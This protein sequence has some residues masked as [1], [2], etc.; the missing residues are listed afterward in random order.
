MQA[1]SARA[2]LIALSLAAAASPVR[3]DDFFRDLNVYVA[4]GAGGEMVWGGTPAPGKGA[5]AEL[6]ILAGRLRWFAFEGGGRIGKHEGTFLAEEKK[7]RVLSIGFNGLVYFASWDS[8]ELFAQI[9]WHPFLVGDSSGNDVV[10]G[11]GIDYWVATHVTVGVR[12]LY[13]HLSWEPVL[14][15]STT[16]AT[17]LS[18]GLMLAF[19]LEPPPHYVAF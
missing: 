18:L 13:H 5:N 4:A 3:A 12:A 6:V 1:S 8:L 15:S 19:H 2:A 7:G 11:M 14:A 17:G 9:G 16:S 10:A